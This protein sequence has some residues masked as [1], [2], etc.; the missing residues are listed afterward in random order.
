MLCRLPDYS[1]SEL[2]KQRIY[3]HAAAAAASL[4]LSPPP[5]PPPP[6]RLLSKDKCDMGVEERVGERGRKEESRPGEA[7]EERMCGC[8]SGRDCLPPCDDVA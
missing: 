6:P 7:A 5:P 3:V 4:P 8:G 1:G 2:P